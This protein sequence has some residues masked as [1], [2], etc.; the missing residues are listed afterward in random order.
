VTRL[1]WLD[2]PD[3]ARHRHA[4]PEREL[5][6]WG[7]AVEHLQAAGLPAAVPELAAAWLARRGIRADWTVAA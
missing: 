4:R 7:R 6:A 1:P 2:D 3:C 5:P